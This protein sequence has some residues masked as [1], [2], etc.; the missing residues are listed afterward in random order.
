M[1]ITEVIKNLFFPPRCASC[2]KVMGKP[3][4]F[5]GTCMPEIP[6]VDGITC[7]KCGISLSANFPAPICARC[8]D[9]K[10]HFD[11]NI[12]LMEHFGKGREVVLNMKYRRPSVINDMALLMAKRIASEE[13]CFDAVTFV[14][15]TKKDENE[16]E[17]HTTYF[18]SKRIAKILRCR[19]EEL[20]IKVRE[21]K[22]Q[23]ELTEKGRITNV[24]GAYKVTGDVKDKCILLVD[25][26]FTTGATMDECA[27]ILKRAGAKE[28]ITASLSIRDRE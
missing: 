16:K 11:K 17:I 14:P 18:L 13:K 20:L 15:M 12:P 9:R 21:T 27:K 2:F 3:V 24:L 5:C 26:V 1:K 6:F 7:D 19:H 22:K 4:S 10:F 25:D 8:N 23:K 28:V